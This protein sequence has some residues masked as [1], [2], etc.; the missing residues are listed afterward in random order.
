MKSKLLKTL[1]Q[2]K[3]GIYS[4]LIVCYDPSDY[5]YY[6]ENVRYD[7]DINERIKEID[8][9]GLYI[10]AIYNYNL[11][12][13]EQLIEYKPMNI[14]PIIKE[15]SKVYMASEFAQKDTCKSI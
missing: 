12:L 9:S 6:L 5:E 3:N 13:D 1:K 4:H 10:E 14:E 7:R 11:D 8:N 2:N 15:K